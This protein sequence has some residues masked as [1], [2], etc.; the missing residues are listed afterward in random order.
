MGRWGSMMRAD[1]I[2]AVVV[3]AQLVRAPDCGSGGWG[4]KSP[5]PPC[6]GG[7]VEG[8]GGRV[9]FGFSTSLL[10]PPWWR[11]A[12]G[13]HRL[14]A[15]LAEHRSPKPGVAGSS[16]AGPVA[17]DGKAVW[18]YGGRFSAGCPPSCCLP[19]VCPTGLPPD[20]SSPRQ[21]KAPNAGRTLEADG[22][23]FVLKWRYGTTRTESDPRMRVPGRSGPR[24]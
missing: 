4:F 3:V 22:Y 11:R 13:W 9:R 14:V 23:F 24:L 19:P 20:V 5:Q 10:P 21:P 7:V 17:K 2:E 8:G 12:V 15:Q 1:P 18:R 6:E 16:P